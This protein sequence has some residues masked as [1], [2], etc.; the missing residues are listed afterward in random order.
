LVEQWNGTTW[1]Q[2]ASPDA[3]GAIWNGFTAISC[4]SATHCFAV[5]NYNTDVQVDGS[6]TSEWTLIEHYS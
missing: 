5:G 4:T 1:T 2:I 3:P 6:E